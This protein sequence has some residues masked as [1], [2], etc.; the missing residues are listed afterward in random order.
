MTNDSLYKHLTV[1]PNPKNLLDILDSRFRWESGL[2]EG[3]YKPSNL[4]E[5]RT[6]L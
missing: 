2:C 4:K 3:G 5:K 1:G 6:H